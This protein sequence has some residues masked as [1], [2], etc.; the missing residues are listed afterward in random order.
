MFSF[1]KYELYLPS[2]VVKKDLLEKAGELKEEFDG[3]Q[4]YDFG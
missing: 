2:G 1:E 3:A 4:D